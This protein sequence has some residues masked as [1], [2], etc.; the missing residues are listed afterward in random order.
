MT[1]GTHESWIF[2][3]TRISL[4]A[5]LLCANCQIQKPQEPPSELSAS[6]AYSPASPVA[7]QP[8][9][10]TDT[11]TGNPTSWEWALGDGATNTARNPSHTYA[12]AGSYE[13]IL[14][15][16]AGTD[17]NSASRTVTVVSEPAGYYIDANNPNA[18]DSN[19]GTESLPW[20]TITKA[21]QAL[22]AGDTV[23]IKA[24]TY[25]S[26]I[27]PTRSG[28][29]SSRITYR[30]YGSDIVTI[31]NA[32]YGIRLNGRSYITVLG[33]DFYNLDRFMYLENGSNYNIIAYCNFDQMR[34][35]VEWAGS[36]IIGNS[37]HNWVH[38]SRFSKYGSVTGTP[39]NGSSRGVVFDIGDEESPTDFSDYNLIEN[40]VMYHGGHHV[41]GVNS[42]YN[43]IRN[44]YMHNEAWLQGTGQRVIYTAGYAASAGW[45]L[46]E[47]N[48]FNYSEVGAN[49][50]ITEGAQISTSHNIFRFNEM[51]F[52]DGP[53]L[54]LSASS[55][56]YQSVNYNH[57]YNNSFFRNVQ[58]EESDPSNVA[59]YFGV[60]GGSWVIK[61][62]A[63]KNNLYYGH[64]AAYG[65]Y[66]VSLGDQ[67]FANEFNGDISG[68]PKFVNASTALGDPMDASY[69]DLQLNAGSPCIDKGGGL[70]TIT[71]SSGSG[72][73]FTVAD[74]AYFMDGWGIFGV[75]G[76]EIQIVGTSQ[77]ARINNV[78]YGTNTLTV[79]INLNWTQGQEIALAYIG[80]AP[81]AGANE[82]G[83]SQLAY[84]LN[85][86]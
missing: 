14:T 9:L 35:L 41:L 57:I 27:A 84:A 3:R 49:G 38:H 61:Y 58:T 30:A 50:N 43:V 44:N 75:K 59:L 17:S 40:N 31:Q 67:T 24:G 62:N 80:G 42:R 39:P 52:N 60:W 81:D 20:K 72:I 34:S 1:Y 77:K 25:T 71:S 78:N 28:T 46:F 23:Y 21:N 10:F 74:A 56:Y 6:F 79:N 32:A 7:G 33:I 19:P 11:S 51:S 85:I 29:E 26:Y 45:N 47:G 65:V 63:I 73:S 64:P 54:M 4:I 68:D 5:C 66:A 37:S 2:R 53:G 16:R 55:S 8:V 86:K 48:K 76:D 36:R 22:V 18:S 12:A 69:P 15:I 13:V 70:T 82:F 83:S